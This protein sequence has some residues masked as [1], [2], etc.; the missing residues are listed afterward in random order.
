MAFVDVD[1]GTILDASA[2]SAE[3]NHD[4]YDCSYVALARAA[5]A[6]VLV[7]TDRDLGRL[8]ADEPF[9]YRNPVPEDVLERFHAVT[10]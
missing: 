2:V 7:T 8:C 9:E 6:D 4:V 5:D 3:R 10:D 1:G